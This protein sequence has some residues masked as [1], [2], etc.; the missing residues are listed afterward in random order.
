MTFADLGDTKGFSL[1][2]YLLLIL[3]S[4]LIPIVLLNL[5]IS[6]VSDTFANF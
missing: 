4:L 2:E 3:I 6:L 5:L 1:N